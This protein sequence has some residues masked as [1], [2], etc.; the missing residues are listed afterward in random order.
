MFLVPQQRIGLEE[1]WHFFPGGFHPEVFSFQFKVN[2]LESTQALQANN[3]LKLPSTKRYSR[4]NLRKR[5]V[6]DFLV[7][8][9]GDDC[10]FCTGI[11]FHPFLLS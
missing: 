9:I 3:G 11:S 8:L 2:K 4:L 10:S 1:T 6:C 7:Q 5:V